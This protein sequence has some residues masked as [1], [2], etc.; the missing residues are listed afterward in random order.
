MAESDDCRTRVCY[1]PRSEQS[2]WRSICNS[3]LVV[4]VVVVFFFFP[5]PPFLCAFDVLIETTA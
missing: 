5:P 1:S 3:L 4:V 2:M